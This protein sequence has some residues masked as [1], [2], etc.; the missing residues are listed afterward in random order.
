MATLTF[1]AKQLLS[2]TVR[3]LRERLLRD[4]HDAAE[5]R[6]R[7][8]LPLDKARLSED[9][10]KK[11]ERLEAWLDERVRAATPKDKKAA[12]AARARALLETQKEAAATLLNRL[13]LLRHLEALGL[14]RPAVVTGG[15]SAKG[16]QELRD[17]AP[18][19][20][21][22][23]T[24]GYAA[25][26]QLVSTSSRSTCPASS[27]TWGSRASSR[28]RRRRCARWCSGSTIRGSRRP[29]PTTRRWAGSIST[30]TTRSAR[31]STQS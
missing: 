27:A 1:E 22:D 10:G 13:V 24:E 23:E 9:A 28:C 16:Y 31:R 14:S 30:G 8:S 25:L 17:F 2:R 11:R 26:L 3:D 6:Y 15:W 12:D 29:G 19:L 5:G 4:L 20:C 18:A 21:A 7:L